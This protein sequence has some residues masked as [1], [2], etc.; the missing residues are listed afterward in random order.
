MGI[1]DRGRYTE[2][3]TEGHPVPSHPS[4]GGG[5]GTRW[6]EGRQI[7][8][9]GHLC[10]VLGLLPEAAAPSTHGVSVSAPQEAGEFPSVLS[11]RLPEIL[12]KR[13]GASL[14]ASAI[15]KVG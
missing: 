6:A 8:S 15:G 1:V 2:G 4:P 14:L 10:L 3:Q 13:S 12:E 11:P 7:N 9:E 5:D